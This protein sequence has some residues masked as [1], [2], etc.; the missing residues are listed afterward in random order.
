MSRDKSKRDERKKPYRNSKPN[1][2]KGKEVEFNVPDKSLNKE[3]LAAI[4]K[5]RKISGQNDPAWYAN[6]PQLLK[7]A[8]SFPYSWPVGAP[9]NMG[10][11]TRG[12]TKSLIVYDEAVP[13]IM[14]FKFIPTIGYSADPT[15]PINIAARQIYSFVRHA[16]SGHS[17]YDSPDLMMYLIA[18]DSAYLWLSYMTRAYGTAMLYSPVNRYLP[19]A[20]L[21]AQNLDAEDIFENL[22]QLRFYINEYAYKIAS[23]CVPGG[24]TY[25]TRHAWLSTNVYLDADS[26]KAQMYLFSPSVYYVFREQVQGPGYLASRSTDVVDSPLSN[27]TVAQLVQIGKEIIEPILSS[28]DFNIMSGD[29]LKAFGSDNL[30]K[31]APISED[32]TV[33]PIYSAEVNSQIENM[34]VPGSGTAS[35]FGTTF[36]TT[37]G[38]NDIT[39]DVQTGAII[40][41][42]QAQNKYFFGGNSSESFEFDTATA[43]FWTGKIK[44]NMHVPDVSPEQTMVATRLIPCG[45]PIIAGSTTTSWNTINLTAYGSEIIS[46]IKVF[47]MIDGDAKFISNREA[48]N[49]TNIIDVRQVNSYNTQ[50]VAS[51]LPMYIMHLFS[52]FDWSPALRLFVQ[53]SPQ[54][55]T[56][57]GYYIGDTFDTDNYT[58]IDQESMFR[59]H[60]T[61]LLSMFSVPQMA[62][63]SSKPSTTR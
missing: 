57:Q 12:V 63:I 48:M 54:S 35:S 6:S 28:E 43:S 19:K 25:F 2:S 37:A 18:M 20:L 24:M 59:M 3:D 22:A 17:N 53:N 32:Y 23:M 56:V 8:A 16:N 13:G 9:V 10:M 15:S 45:I 40:Q 49:L 62:A 42:F 50:Y 34:I 58:L 55:S 1:R 41:K 14:A 60:E 26:A 38:V 7:D 21:K 51:M 5:D 46:D 33:M 27:L 4:V 29:I 39:Q 31:V 61:A 11:Q 47:T 30:I 52:Q 44:V 36:P